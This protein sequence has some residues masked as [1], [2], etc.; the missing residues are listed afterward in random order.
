MKGIRRSKWIVVFEGVLSVVWLVAMGL[1][2]FFLPGFLT[3]VPVFEIKEVYVYGLSSVPA[4]AIS[5]GV[6]QVS[7]NSWLFLDDKKLLAKVNELAGNAVENVRVE[8]AFS[9]D[10]VRVSVYVKER[11][12]IAYLVH[13]E[14]VM[15]LDG[16]GEVF[17]NPA[18][19]RELP[20][21]YTFSLDYIKKHHTSLISL[22]RD[23]KEMK[24]MY[25]AKDR[26][27]L[28]TANGKAVLPP[29]SKLSPL[30]LDRLKRLYSTVG[31]KQ[32]EIFMIF[33]GVGVVRERE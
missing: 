28:Y 19:E 29:L 6:Y 7:K 23:V 15:M 22:I 18:M 3:A 26:T 27:T 20:T 13:A 14:K 30:V 8:R 12:P 2:G 21:I 17:Y 4:D 5:L 1:A 31:E 11:E 33:E 24:E 16:N 25:I 9:L 32:V 10:G